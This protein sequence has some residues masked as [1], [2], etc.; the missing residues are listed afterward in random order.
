MQSDRQTVSSNAHTLI[1]DVKNINSIREA[2]NTVK[3]LLPPS[4]GICLPMFYAMF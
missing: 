4:A 1:L 3:H 2:V